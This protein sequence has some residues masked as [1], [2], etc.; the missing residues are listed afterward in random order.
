VKTKRMSRREFLY[1]SGTVTSATL[2]AACAPKATP[3][4]EPAPEEEP[5]VTPQAPAA[6]AVVIEFLGEPGVLEMR[7]EEA[8][9]FEGENPGIEWV[10]V[11]QAEGVSRLEQLLSL[12]A[13]G[14]PPDCARVESD[15]YRTFCK[16]D[17]LL[18][19]SA[20]IKADPEL[21]KPDYWIQPQESD[22]CM[23][24]GEWYGIG[25]CWVAPH[26]YYNK[27]LFDEL[28]VE[29]PSNDPDE[30]WTWDEFLEIARQLTVDTNGNHP[31]DAGFDVDNTDRWGVYWPT[32]WIPLHA[33]VQSNGADWVDPETGKIVLDNPAAMEALQRVADLTLVHQVAPTAASFDALGMGEA[34]FLETKKVALYNTGSW[35]LN[36]LWEIEGGLGTGVLPKM[37]R[38]GTDM[39]AHI[40]VI[41][42]ETE[43]P[44][45]AWKLIRFLSLPWFQERYCQ[46]GLWLPSQTALM[47]DEAIARWCTPPIH[48]P[49]YELIVTEYA[50]KY[51]HY[52]TMPA[53]YAKAAE[54]AL[55]PVFDQ[56]WIGDA[57][58][59]DVLPAAVTEANQ[60][61]EE[62]QARGT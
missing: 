52:L 16:D 25:S 53:G 36:W 31:G 8:E 13:A 19:I 20:N 15:V 22:R 42:K 50:P 58:A 26:F 55:Q 17:L 44:N 40:I 4:E 30:A 61:M 51:G 7:D 6:E 33:A 24:E 5:Q 57:K 34:Q 32:W 39:Q 38:P 45:E 28:G 1:L 23:Y 2:L 60:V 29:P 35:A 14:T 11:E 3:V 62:E 18:G 48:P 56:I 37:T 27:S 46:Q 43:H 41:V 49:G 12:V 59:E 9:K 54:T 47:A 10:Q 21:S